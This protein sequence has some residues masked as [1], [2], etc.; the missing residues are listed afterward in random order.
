MIKNKELALL[1]S[2]HPPF[3]TSARDVRHVIRCFFHP[4]FVRT[5]WGRRV[6]RSLQRPGRH[7]R[8]PP[9][10]RAGTSA[11]CGVHPSKHSLRGQSLHGVASVLIRV[12]WTLVIQDALLISPFACRSLRKHTFPQGAQEKPHDSR[13]KLID[14]KP[15]FQFCKQL[16]PCSSSPG[17]GS[18]RTQTERPPHLI[19]L[20]SFSIVPEREVKDQVSTESFDSPGN[21]GSKKEERQT[22]SNHRLSETGR[23]TPKPPPRHLAPVAGPLPPPDLSPGSA[24]LGHRECWATAMPSPHGTSSGR[25]VVRSGPGWRR[26]VTRAAQALG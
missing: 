8:K 20:D 1:V 19:Y 13:K 16:L 17:F 25:Q 15:H 21:H 22:D 23:L 3:Q 24:E 6:D 9:D 26:H 12:W 10:L 2:H 5:L 4:F 7:R 11:I 18:L 14:P